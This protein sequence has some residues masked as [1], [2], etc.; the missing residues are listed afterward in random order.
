M[1]EKLKTSSSEF[2]AVEKKAPLNY[3]V[4]LIAC[5]AAIAGVLFGFDTAAISGAMLFINKTFHLTDVMYELLTGAVLVG[6][7]LGAIVGG[8]FADYF[9]RR[10]LLILTALLF[11]VGTL[12]SAFSPSVSWLM[13]SRI[14]IGFAIGVASFTTPLYISEIAPPRY[15]GA[16]VSLNQLAI[17]IGILCAYGVNVYFAG[18]GQWRWMLGVGVIPAAILFFG[19]LILPQ[20]PRWIV[21]RGRVDL[22]KR[23]LKTIRGH[24]NVE[25]E[26]MEIQNTLQEKSDWR[27]LFQRWLMPALWIGVGLAFFQQCTGINT[28]VYY[29][30]K[31]F[32]FAGVQSPQGAISTTAIVGIANVV[33]TIIALPLIDL[34]GRRPLLLLGLIGMTISLI[35]LSLSFYLGAGETFLKWLSLASMVI[36]IASFAMSLGPIMWLIIAEVFPLEVRG[37]GSS[38]AIAVSW[39]FNALVAFTFLTL[40]N[41]LGTGGTFLLYAALSALGI[42]FVYKV[43]PETKGVSLEHLEANLRAGVPSRKLGGSSY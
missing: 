13:V 39:A 31:I 20:S 35:M 18:T 22:A 4:I 38:L 14:V 17:T 30:P 33:F 1:S 10:L 16:L 8:R 7:V 15:R 36:Y 27:L 32:Q 43:V 21:L 11:V 12:S 37:V 5:I 34:W 40:I 42:I 9:G 23:I 25:A 6:A 41:H 3:F 24:E 2:T 26:L 29:A 19:M 28:I